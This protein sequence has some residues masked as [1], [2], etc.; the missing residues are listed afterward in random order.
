MKLLVLFVIALFAT[1][2]FAQENITKE[3]L[4]GKFRPNKDRRFIYKNGEYLRTETFAAFNLMKL[5]AAKSGINLR[6]ES[7]TRTFSEQKRLWENKWMARTAVN[8]DTREFLPKPFAGNDFL[9][10]EQRALRILEFTAMPSAS[11]HHW[12]TDLDINNVNPSYWT[13][14]RGQKEYSWLIENAPKFGF[15]QVYS[16]NRPSGYKEE[17]WH[18]S[19]LPIARNLTNEYVSLITD[20]DITLTSFIGAETAITTNFIQNFVLGINPNCK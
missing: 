6:I 13:T 3:Y 16:A 10:K 14:F 20:S 8:T 2:C 12:G 9:T 15:C 18:W 4:M 19:Y 11:R 1:V 17:K 7:A 5:E